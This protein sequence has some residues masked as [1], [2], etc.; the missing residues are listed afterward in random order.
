MKTKKP[1]C[2]KCNIEM[3]KVRPLLKEH[4]NMYVCRSCENLNEVKP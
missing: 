3:E 1:I 2:K 4:K